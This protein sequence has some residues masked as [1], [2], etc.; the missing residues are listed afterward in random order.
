MGIDLDLL[1]YRL[2]VV[3][4]YYHRYTDKLL[5]PIRLPGTHNG[6]SAQ[7]QNAYGILNEGL[8]VM[9]KWDIMREREVKWNMTFNI[10]RNWNRLKKSQNG[11]D[12]MSNAGL[13][14]MNV[15]GKPLNG[16]YAFKTAGYYNFAD[17]VPYYEG[18]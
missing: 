2:G 15:I 8:E 6:Y 1:N 5:Y 12:F 16:I 9:V 3:V 17:E 14:N 7:W 18:E 13:N 10:A 11:K 4:D